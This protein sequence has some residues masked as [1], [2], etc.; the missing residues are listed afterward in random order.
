M[1]GC[2]ISDDPKSLIIWL[3]VCLS[4]FFHLKVFPLK[5]LKNTLVSLTISEFC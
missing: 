2:P 5:V 4:D 3:K 1:S